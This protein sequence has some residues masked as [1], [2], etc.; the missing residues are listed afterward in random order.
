MVDISRRGLLRL[1]AGGAAAGVVGGAGSAL[2]LK[3]QVASLTNSAS[4][5]STMGS[6]PV[7]TSGHPDLKEYTSFKEWIAGA[8]GDDLRREARDFSR[9]DPDIVDM[10]LPLV[11]KHRMQV[12][13]NMRRML[14]EAEKSFWERIKD[15]GFVQEW[16]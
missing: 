5:A 15:S 12:D 13:R 1:G 8:P 10:H 2:G 9:Y 16:A 11:T 7:V 6:A 4:L 3:A 14:R